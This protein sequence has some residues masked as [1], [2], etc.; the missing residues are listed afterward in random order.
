MLQTINFSLEEAEKGVVISFA[1]PSG[2][3]P[4]KDDYFLYFDCPVSLPKNPPT[5]LTFNPASASYVVSGQSSFVPKIAVKIKSLHRSETQNLLRLTIKDNLNYVLYTDY[6]LVVCIPKATISLTSTLLRSDIASNIGPNGGSKIVVNDT[7]TAVSELTQGMVVSG[8]GIPSSTSPSIRTV[9][10]SN[11]FELS[12]LI[13][14]SVDRP[15]TY[16]FTRSV[17]CADPEVLLQRES[18]S[19]YIVLD[20]NNNWTYTYN[21]RFIARFD[22]ID[23]NDDSLIVFLPAKN[24]ALFP[25]DDDSSSI[26]DSLLVNIAG[27]VIGDTQCIANLSFT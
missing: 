7:S 9:I 22:R 26:P 3:I 12:S 13:T 17:K 4:R 27:R 21:D 24:V 11:E 8:P 18:Q 15:G 1:N 16:T 14:T 6:L 25:G 10:T 20:K 2:A 5:T 19:Q 23:K